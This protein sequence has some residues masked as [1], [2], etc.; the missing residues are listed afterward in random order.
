M[1]ILPMTYDE[2]V[3]F[4]K[5]MHDK[6]FELVAIRNKGYSPYANPFT[7]F[8]QQKNLLEPVFKERFPLVEMHGRTGDKH[9]RT[10]TFI[11]QGLPVHKDKYDE[12]LDATNYTLIQ[13]AWWE[14]LYRNDPKLVEGNIKK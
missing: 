8:M 9:S 1:N 2:F 13:A 10:E 4:I 12:F 6:A 14:T 5:E 3:S 7:N 11:T